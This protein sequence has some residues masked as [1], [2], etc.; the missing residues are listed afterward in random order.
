MTP[1]ELHELRQRANLHGLAIAYGL[2]R[3]LDSSTQ[4]RVR[5]T[6]PACMGE[7]GEINII[8]RMWHCLDCGAQGDVFALVRALLRCDL[9]RAVEIVRQEV[10]G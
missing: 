5:M 2:S 3:P 1:Q 7:D 10:D 4:W 9:A 6:C 8:R